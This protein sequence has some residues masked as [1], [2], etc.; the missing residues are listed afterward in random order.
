M[1]RKQARFV[2]Q[3]IPRQLTAQERTVI[4]F[5]PQDFR[6]LRFRA[7]GNLEVDGQNG[8]G[9]GFPYQWFEDERPGYGYSSFRGKRA[10]VEHNCVPPTT[11]IQMADYSYR[12]IADVKVGDEVLTHDNRTGKVSETFRNRHEGPMVRIKAMGTIGNLPLTPGHPVWIIPKEEIDRVRYEIDRD[13]NRVS[14]LS[15]EEKKKLFTEYL[16]KPTF[17]PAENVRLRDH[18]VTPFPTDC[19]VDPEIEDIRYARLLG[20]YL[21]EGWACSSRVNRDGSRPVDHVFYAFSN[22]E[23]DNVN[24]VV[25]NITELGLGKAKV[26]VSTGLKPG[27]EGGTLLIQQSCASFTRL[28]VRHCGR[29]AKEKRLSRSIMQMPP[30]WKIA[31]LDAYF[32]GDGCRYKGTIAANT[33]SPILAS[34]IRQLVASLGGIVTTGKNMQK[35]PDSLNGKP[36][37]GRLLPI[38]TMD[39]ALPVV[40][41]LFPTKRTEGF[42]SIS[43]QMVTDFGIVSPVSSL[44]YI[45]YSDDVCNFEVEG[46]HSYVASNI[47]THN[48]MEGYAGSIG[49]LPDCY[50]NRFMLPPEIPHGLKFADL[51]PTQRAQVLSVPNQRDGSIEVLMRIDMTMVNRLTHSAKYGRTVENLIRAIDTEQSIGSSMGT[52]VQYSHCS[53][54]GNEARF[55]NEYCNDLK[56]KKNGV[57]SV[58]SNQI[59]DL[60]DAGRLRPE[61]VRHFATRPQDYTEIVN[62][63]NNHNVLMRIAEINHELSFF[64]LSVVARPAYHKGYDLEKIAMDEMLS[65][66]Q[67]GTYTLWTN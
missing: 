51:S 3:V 37:S 53:V 4:P 11:P 41:Q 48:S 12:P 50:L 36:D 64:E 24:E 61:W 31:F 60:L 18:V 65:P 55:A 54:C 13:G 39:L 67:I 23:P 22:H 29:K 46:E 34:Q 63:V 62:G 38:Y 30:M 45:D 19:F 17:V 6:Y 47:V 26:E 32:R 25:R 7:I 57:A 66:S 52:D 44:D 27:W 40:E 5:N 56:W 14:K 20:F 2:G 10:H 33:A 59:R 21:A 35:A 49:D 9:D 15:L 1:L 8:N 16:P 58:S 43:N 28:A 42:R